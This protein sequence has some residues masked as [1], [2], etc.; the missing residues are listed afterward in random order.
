MHTPHTYHTAPLQSINPGC[1]SEFSRTKVQNDTSTRNNSIST[2]THS[3]YFPTHTKSSSHHPTPLTMQDILEM[4]LPIN[5]RA[6]HS[7]NHTIR[8][9]CHCSDV[10]GMP[11]H[12]VQFCLQTATPT[13]TNTPERVHII[14]ILN[15]KHNAHS[16]TKHKHTKLLSISITGI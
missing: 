12:T 8:R 5:Q 3:N 15:I 14:Q 2:S 13:N 6:L 4:S 7:I 9:I 10:A 16:H 1:V 11:K